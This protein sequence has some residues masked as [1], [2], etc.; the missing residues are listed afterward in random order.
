VEATCT[1]TGLTEGKSCSRCKEVLVAQTETPIA[2]HTVV[3]DAAVAPTCTSTGKTE[4]SHCQVCGEIIV[5]QNILPKADHTIVVTEAIKPTTT[6][7]GKTSGASCSVCNEVFVAVTDI[8]AIKEEHKDDNHYDII[9][10]AAP[11]PTVSGSTAVGHTPN[12]E[13]Y[14]KENISNA[15]HDTQIVFRNAYNAIIL[16]PS[17][18]DIAIG[19][20]S[21]S[22][23]DSKKLSFGSAF[24]VSDIAEGADSYNGQYN[25]TI[26]I[27]NADKFAALLHYENGVWVVVEG[28]TADTAAGTVTFTVN[29]LSPFATVLAED[30]VCT[31]TNYTTSVTA[32]TCVAAGYTT[33]T[34]TACGETW[35]GD[36]TEATGVHTFGDDNV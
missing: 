20:D 36:E 17:I 24:E 7:S 22:I 9:D 16:A 29:S 3:V 1:S 35:T 5:K 10:G 33:Y 8:P 11:A 15:R 25:I 28:A 26:N 14:D 2:D 31:H 30:T 23:P 12:I 19:L 32:P 34:C 4:G 6:T 13:I 18:K 21:V 27:E